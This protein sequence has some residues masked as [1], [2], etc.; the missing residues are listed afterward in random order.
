MPTFRVPPGTSELNERLT[1][2]SRSYFDRPRNFGHSRK[3]PLLNVWELNC[4]FPVNLRTRPTTDSGKT[5]RTESESAWDFSSVYGS[6]VAKFCR[7]RYESRRRQRSASASTHARLGNEEKQPAFWDTGREG[8][9]LNTHISD[10]K[11]LLRTP[12]SLTE[13]NFGDQQLGDS[14]PNQKDSDQ[15]KRARERLAKLV[16]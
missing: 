6:S 8:L 10:R 12:G 4:G 2:N 11:F 3:Q 16:L 13:R 7:Q 15:I 1:K 9:Q 14:L 5:S